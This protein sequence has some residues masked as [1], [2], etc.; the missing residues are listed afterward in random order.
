M[1]EEALKSWIEQA[2]GIT[3]VYREPFAGD[4][5]PDPSVGFKVLSFAYPDFNYSINSLKDANTVAKDYKAE[6][7]MLVSLNVYSDFAYNEINKLAISENDYIA[8][9]TLKSANMAINGNSGLNNLTEL[10]VNKKTQRWQTD[11]TFN[12]TLSHVIDVAKIQN[13]ILH[14]QWRDDTENHYLLFNTKQYLVFSD[15]L[16]LLFEDENLPINST[17]EA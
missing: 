1:I 2:T 8:R 4:K 11:F 14:G 16:Y 7:T 9:N 3:N 13:W 12:I 10:E 5:L 15:D 6:A 17:I